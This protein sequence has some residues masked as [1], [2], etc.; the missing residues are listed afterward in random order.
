MILGLSAAAAVAW[1][2]CPAG[3]RA[4][5]LD[6]PEVEF[7]SV[8]V[9]GHSNVSANRQG[10]GCGLWPPA[11][12]PAGGGTKCSN[13]FWFP[14]SSFRTGVGGDIFQA[15]GRAGDGAPCGQWAGNV[16]G[17]P[18]AACSQA[19]ASRDGGRTYSLARTSS[20]G[21]SGGFPALPELL[22]ELLPPQPSTG[23]ST[24]GRFTTLANAIF[25]NAELG[26]DCHTGGY[27]HGVVQNCP[28]LLD[29]EDRNGSIVLQGNRSVSFT[30]VPA[31]F[32]APFGSCGVNHCG[33]LQKGRIL[34][35]RSGGLLAAFDGFAADAP[36]CTSQGEKGW[37][38]CY[39]IALFRANSSAATSW[40]YV[41]RVDRTPAMP[42]N[43]EGP[44]EPSMAQLPDG[45]VM[46][47]F[48]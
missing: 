41:G 11:T 33:G 25:G 13:H 39:T 10:N 46:M 4:E 34:R 20:I 16:K 24:G 6:L 40:E 48:R 37:T 12:V 26:M 43:V 38:L 27:G 47:I 31:E 36:N 32:A 15:I 2:H 7:E 18:A 28:M 42:S 35:L 1:M 22:G 19:F 21:W 5:A 30:H 29:W 14:G 23:S 44:S 3:S 8:S 45:R 9:V 17:P